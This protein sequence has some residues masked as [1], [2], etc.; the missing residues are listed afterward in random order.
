MGKLTTTIAIALLM[1]SHSACSIYK[2]ASQPGPADL[3]HLG[4]G[5]PRT[6]VIASLGI[7]K[8]SDMDP[9]GRKQDIFE[10][11]SGFNQASKARILP[12]LAA[13]VFTLGLAELVLWPIEMTVME[14]A[15]C[16]AMA[17]YDPSQKV[18]TWRVTQKD[19]FQGC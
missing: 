15:V 2:V 10:F 12:Y 17:T 18:E 9:E 6:Q 16:T 3:S 14:R 1:A 19:G 7:P 13:D 4:I 5:S 8:F 11:Q